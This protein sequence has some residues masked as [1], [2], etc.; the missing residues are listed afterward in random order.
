MCDTLSTREPASEVIAD[1]AGQDDW[2]VI[3]SV[4]ETADANVVASGD[5]IL[6][7]LRLGK[8]SW[9]AIPVTEN[10]FSIFIR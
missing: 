1:L 3:A 8:F 10:R 4:L 7:V 2:R 5:P 9:P 6:E